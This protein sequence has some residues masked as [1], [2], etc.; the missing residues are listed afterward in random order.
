V[1]LLLFSTL[2]RKG[3][4]VINMELQPEN[5]MQVTI[6]CIGILKERN[7]DVEQ[8]VS[9][10]GKNAQCSSGGSSGGS[11]G[12]SSTGSPVSGLAQKKRSTRCR[13]VFRCRLP[14]S[15]ASGQPEILQVV[16]SPI[17]CT[18]PLGTPEICKMSLN[19]CELSG[20]RELFIIGKNFLKDT[21]VIFKNGTW[22]RSCEPDKEY[23]HSVRALMP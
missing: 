12:S 15:N 10:L 6:D 11:S 7:V 2:L 18:Q 8:K 23:L 4:T 21:R 17:L 16:S 20:G 5:D 3:T 13:L 1:F 19:E 9:R 14:T 22:N